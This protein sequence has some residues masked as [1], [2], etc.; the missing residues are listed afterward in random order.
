MTA[1]RHQ[2][3]R[4]ICTIIS[5]IIFC[6]MLT[7]CSSDDK[8]S[9]EVSDI[10]KNELVMTIDNE[11]DSKIS[12]GWVNSCEIIVDTTEDT[13]YFEPDAFNRK[14]RKGTNQYSVN[15]SGCIGE[16]RRVEITEICK[17]ND[18][19]LPDYKYLRDVV[20]YDTDKGIDSYSGSFPALNRFDIIMIIIPSVFFVI[21]AIFVIIIIRTK[22]SNKRAVAQFN[23]FGNDQNADTY[24]NFVMRE[25]NRIQNDMNNYA[26]QQNINMH[27]QAHQHAVDINNNNNGFNPPPSPPN[28]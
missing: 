22:K 19:N 17:L 16:I 15:I 1:K 14:F 6:L 20:V 26:H 5:V 13:Y 18:R 3:F 27:N 25:N 9:I 28:F 21:V 10:T 11:T 8:V 2:K 12:L 24:H 4:F 23:P 7:G